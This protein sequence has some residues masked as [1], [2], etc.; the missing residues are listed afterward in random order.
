MKQNKV[1]TWKLHSGSSV[2]LSA[3]WR[4][5]WCAVLRVN[6]PVHK[7]SASTLIYQR[8]VQNFKQGFLVPRDLFQD[9]SRTKVEGWMKSCTDHGCKSNRPC[10]A[11]RMVDISTNRPHI[12]E[13]KTIS[14]QYTALSHCWG[15]SKMTRLLLWNEEQW[16]V[17]IEES[18]LSRNFQDAMR[19]TR[20]LGFNYIWIDAL[21]IIQ[22]SPDE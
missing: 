22:D 5:G 15:L 9:S 7:K 21:C 4:H 11:K 14:G 6:D 20:V 19:I 3:T 2:D 10:S 1:S 12:A 18:S 16:R 13:A 17:A 8:S